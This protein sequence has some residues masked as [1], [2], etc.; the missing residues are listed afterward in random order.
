MNR[1][2]ARQILAQS[3]TNLER[4]NGSVTQGDLEAEVIN[5]ACLAIIKNQNKKIG[6]GKSIR[7]ILVGALNSTDDYYPIANAFIN[8]AKDLLP[9]YFSDEEETDVMT[10]IEQNIAWEGMWDFLVTYF[11]TKHGIKIDEGETSVVI[12]FSERQQKFED[13]FL[14]EDTKTDK[15]IYLKFDVKKEKLTVSIDPG[16][17]EFEALL[18]DTDDETFRYRGKQ[19]NYIISVNFDD[20]DEVESFVLDMPEQNTEIIYL[21][22]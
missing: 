9:E 15:T 17:S 2:K 3:I 11:R 19:N 18:I 5:N 1:E 12:F 6:N 10:G 14:T 8:A 20:Y 21:E 7:D 13:G 22:Y 16:P 4:R